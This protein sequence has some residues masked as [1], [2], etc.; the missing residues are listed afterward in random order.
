MRVYHDS[1]S[2]DYRSPGGAQPCGTEIRLRLRVLEGAPEAVYARLWFDKESFLPMHPL[3]ED[4]S[5]YEAVFHTPGKPCLLWYDF[6]LWQDGQFH[7]YGNAE[8]SLGGVGAPLWGEA[9]SYQITVYDPAFAAPEWT[10][11]AVI[12]Q[13]FP[14]RFA[15]GISGAKLPMHPERLYH[16][17]WNDIPALMMDPETGDN[18]A[19]DFFG[20]T[21][22]GIREK[23]PYLAGLGVTVLYLNP[24]FH[25]RTNHRFDTIDWQMIDPTLGTLEDFQRLCAEAKEQGIRIILDGVFN[26]SG[27]SSHFFRHAQSTPDSPYRN[28]YKFEHWPDMYKSWWGF[29][30]LPDLNN[31]QPEVIDYFLADEDAVVRRWLREGAGGWRIDVADELPMPFLRML[32]QGAKQVQ[33]DTVVIGE[34]WED[35]S[36][37]VSY[38]EMRCY[39]LGDTLDGVMNYPLREAAIGYLTGTMDAHG[40]KRQMDSLYENY[41]MPFA[42]SLMNLLGSHD[43]ARALNVLSGADGHDLPREEQALL[44]LTPAQRAL[45]EKRLKLMLQLVITM[46]GMPCVYY[47][48]ETGMEGCADPFSRGTFPWGHEDEALTAYFTEALARRHKVAPLSDGQLLID[49][50]TADVLYIRRVSDEGEAATLINR[51]DMPVEVEI[52]GRRLQL[53]PFG[54]MMW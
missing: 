45:G 14:D 9:R 44:R 10:R 29:K 18:V 4:A 41:P 47:G 31:H 53:E 48:D 54:C 3:T 17:D 38:G 39:C 24:I 16:E 36:N 26:H 7:W 51:S 33:P 5:L 20:G 35:A 34:V 21:L 49:A 15:R 37:K 46:P 25:A 1:R 6:Q 28:W 2:L 40:F 23:L 50:L 19:H 30:T 52:D 8:D 12:Y 22:E 43:R 11:G 32:H 27:S 42:Q 13:I